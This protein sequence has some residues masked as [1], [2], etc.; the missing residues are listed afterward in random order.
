MSGEISRVSSHANLDA[1]ALRRAFHH[2]R[3]TTIG[4][5]EELMLLDPETLDL[6]PCAPAVLARLDGDPRFTAELPAAQLEIVGR[7]AASVPEAASSLREARSALARAAEGVA[8]PA[9]AGVH[10]F[11]SG[12][13]VVSPGERYRQIL[14]EY[15]GV[16]RRQLVFGLHVHVALG[17]SDRVLAVYNALREQLP[18]LAAL[19]GASPFYEGRDT[20]LASV[21][22]KLSELLPRQGVPPAFTGWEAF[23]RALCWGRELGSFGDARWW[24]EARLHPVHGTIEVR[25]CDTQATVGETASVAAVVHALVATLAERHDAGDLP[26]PAETWRIAEN[27]WSACRHGVQGPWVDARSGAVTP[28]AEHLHA[29]LEELRPAAERLGCAADLAAARS[30]VDHR[31]AERARAAGPHALARSLADRFLAEYEGR[32]SG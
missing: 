27:R 21:R 28:M 24:W 29:L 25:V 20:G 13:G 6:A 17:G 9:G 2:D 30:M 1:D 14:D 10:P 15:G 32:A 11:A 23:A 26:E 16:V 12:V 18:A 19:A 3:P 5:E 7:P 31:A 8:L 22:P 4:L